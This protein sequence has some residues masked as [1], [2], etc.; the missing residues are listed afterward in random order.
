MSEKNIMDVAY[1]Y[2]NDNA[3]DDHNDFR[4]GRN[5][6]IDGASNSR[7]DSSLHVQVSVGVR[8]DGSWIGRTMMDTVV[9]A[10]V[11]EEV[12]FVSG[13]RLLGPRTGLWGLYRGGVDDDHAHTHHPPNPRLCIL[14]LSGPSSVAR[15]QSTADDSN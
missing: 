9:A 11:N 1:T 3:D 14:L 7:Y 15:D 10:D 5:D 2:G 12:G 6:G 8:V 4:N 13:R